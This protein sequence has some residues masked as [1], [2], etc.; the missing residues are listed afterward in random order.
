MTK[1]RLAIAL[2]AG[3]ALAVSAGDSVIITGDEEQAVTGS[4][5]TSG[6]DDPLAGTA[7]LSTVPGALAFTPDSGQDAVDVP[8]A[9]AT[10]AP[11]TQAPATQAPA[12]QAPAT[13]APATQA[14]ATQAPA[15]QAPATQAPATQAP[16]TQAPATQA[17]ATQAPATQ[18]P[19]TQAPATQAPATQAPA[20][21]APA[22]QAPAAAGDCT[23]NVGGGVDP[24]DTIGQAASTAS[25][26]DVVCVYPGQYGPFTNRANGTANA[27]IVYRSV[28]KWGAKVQAPISNLGEY[29]DI[30]GFEVTGSG[31]G[32]LNGNGTFVSHS[33][34]MNNHVYGVTEG[35]VRVVRTRNRLCRLEIQC[36][37][38]GCGR[39]DLR[40]RHPRDRR[41]LWDLHPHPYAKIYDN[42]FYDVNR[43]AIH[44]WHNANYVEVTNNDIS[45]TG[46]GIV[47]GNGDSPCGTI[48]CLQ[49]GYVVT[50]NTFCNNGR[51]IDLRGS[52]H[53]IDGNAYLNTP[54]SGT[55]QKVATCE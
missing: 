40:Q 15:T 43:W 3:F 10:Q 7:S 44:G 17:P 31:D 2:L 30:D 26:G 27:R 34:I 35:G 1:I 41:R 38:S 25:A 51:G 4:T 49:A 20:T 32:I 39:R 18:A 12:T 46:Y 45:D 5:E 19:A 48:T 21:Q 33:W 42:V 8:T 9:P 29:T 37:L 36:P 55:N 11:A 24:F 16:A 13:Q 14:P 47:L 50:G 52:G 23:I 53:T 28:E 6:T 54:A 22:T